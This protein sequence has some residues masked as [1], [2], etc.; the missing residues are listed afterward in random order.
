MIL[1]EKRET[2]VVSCYTLI[3]H[4]KNLCTAFYNIER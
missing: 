4:K 3:E 2:S 1:A